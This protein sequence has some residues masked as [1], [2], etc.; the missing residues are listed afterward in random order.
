MAGLAFDLN[1]PL[2]VAGGIP[3]VAMVL[4]GLWARSRNLTYLLAASASLLT[5][6]GFMLSPNGGVLWIVLTNRGLALLAIWITALIITNRIKESESRAR[7]QRNLEE[8]QRIAGLGSWDWD[9]TANTLVW[10]DEV[11]RIF[12]LRPR[13]FDATYE[14]FLEYLHPD[15]RG[16]LEA[17]VQ[18][19]LETGEHYEIEHRVVRQDGTQRFV[20]ERGEVYLDEAGKPSAMRGT[21]QDVTQEKL[22]QIALVESEAQLAEAQR[23][24]KLGHWSMSPDFKNIDWSAETKRIFGLE[25][26][27]PPLSAKEYTA[28][29]HPDDRA[30]GQNLDKGIAKGKKGGSYNF[31]VVINAETK[32]LHVITHFSR[33]ESGEVTL[34]SGTV[35]DI[36]KEKLAE[37]KIRRLN[38]G[39]ELRVEQRTAELREQMEF[40]ER[41]I[42][43]AQAI[44]LVLDTEGRIKQYNSYLEE[45]TGF[46]LAEVQGKSWFDIFI[47]DEQQASI[48]ALHDDLLVQ[49]EIHGTQ[50]PIRT[51][52]GDILQIEWFNTTLKDGNGEISG[53]LSVGQNI[54]E[55]LKLQAQIIQSSKLATLG[56]MATGIAHELNQPLGI[57]GFAAE[58][59]NKRMAKG[60]LDLEYTS[61]K[62]ERV[63]D[64][65]HRATKIIDHMR[66]FGR[67]PDTNAKPVYLP[68]A[69]DGVMTLIGQQL[70]QVGINVESEVPD[71]LPTLTGHRVQIEQVLL[72]LINNARDA[73]LTAPQEGKKD[74][75]I[76][77]RF[78]SA[79]E[80]IIL[81]VSDTGGGINPEH[82][83]RIFEPFFTT[84][85]INKGTGL[86]LSI[87]YGIVSEMGGRLSAEN[88]GEGASFTLELPIAAT[89]AA[90]M[91]LVL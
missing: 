19:A 76:T 87:S 73:I 58:N 51:K 88:I 57:I 90:R 39:L 63:L 1:M 89:P 24:A 13:Q 55:R 78:D 61:G 12:G 46:P 10:S 62:V 43:T 68:D 40:S 84:K 60:N 4:C 65:V 85:E 34:I 50:N 2:G 82:M 44:I 25:K 79:R 31:R 11:Y 91:K 36:T 52:S 26:N 3:Y 32:F 77:G 86:G 20:I 70:K 18:K 81:T 56:E 59:L 8:A 6:I 9:I 42:D 35:Q 74:I 47:P 5:A 29:I 7:S 21:V 33:N 27:D 37:D 69:V 15:D 67:K 22:S 53:T 38:K 54:T 30:A 83:D 71:D 41:L 72:N 48:D 14:A 28:L 23:M 66:I 45:L 64:Q 75:S 80:T 17:A 16:G 49:G